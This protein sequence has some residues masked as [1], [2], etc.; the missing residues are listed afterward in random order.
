MLINL[1][2]NLSIDLKINNDIN[3][4][5]QLILT[6]PHNIKIYDYKHTNIR[7]ADLSIYLDYI[8]TI[9]I[10][11]Q[12]KHVLITDDTTKPNIMYYVNKLDHIFCKTKT[13]EDYFADITYCKKL[14]Y[15]GWTM[16]DKLN[17]KEF[18]SK[19]TLSYYTFATIDNIDLL[20]KLIEDWP[21]DDKLNVY[22]KLPKD[23]ELILDLVTSNKINLYFDKLPNES[24]FIQ[25]TKERFEY[26]LLEE[27]STGSVLITSNSEI[28][29]DQ[30]VWNNYNELLNI[31]SN[32]IDDIEKRSNLSRK[33]FIDNQYDFLQNFTKHMTILFQSI[34]NK[35]HPDIKEINHIE[36]NPLVSIITPTFNRSNIFKIA[37]SVW[38]SLTYENREWIIV[39]D[40]NE[41]LQLPKDSRILYLKLNS[42][43]N[44]GAKRNIAIENSNGDYILCMDDDDYYPGNII[45]TRLSTLGNS[46]CSYCST[47][48]CYNI[49]KNV[50]FINTPSIYDRPDKRVSEATLFFKRGFWLERGFPIQKQLGEGE[51]F[52]QDRY[53][54]CKE[55]DWTGIIISLLHFKNI[56]G[57]IDS[58]NGSNGNHWKNDSWGFTED[59]LKLLETL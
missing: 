27:A 23:N 54:K 46:D 10:H 34:I 12:G 26:E 53:N 11:K 5:R 57:K 59:F 7:D 36:K 9:S 32:G 42:H 44:I 49:Y 17:N 47:I 48:A 1:F 2:T 38:N 14:H 52:I 20:F 21:I 22:C 3:I 43:L 18:I 28:V 30:Y 19:K 6:P 45:E 13:A 39:D 15:L 33:F 41:P 35:I 50:S 8:N 40:G 25:L 24:I 56:S 4:L 55:L 29:R 16:M 58:V 51:E 37:L 31:I